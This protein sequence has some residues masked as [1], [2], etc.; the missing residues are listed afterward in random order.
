MTD[1]PQRDGC[2]LNDREIEA[3]QRNFYRG[4][5][6]DREIDRLFETIRIQRRVLKELF[7]LWY[8]EPLRRVSTA[9]PVPNSQLAHLKELVSMEDKKCLP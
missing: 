3:V 6:N 2:G 7:G 1:D 5:F 9:E 8:K 4:I